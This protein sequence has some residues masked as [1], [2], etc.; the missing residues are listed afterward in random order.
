MKCKEARPLPITLE[1]LA[2]VAMRPHSS[3]CLLAF[4]TSN[5]KLKK[6]RP[7]TG[8][9]Q[10]NMSTLRAMDSECVYVVHRVNIESSTLANLTV[11]MSYRIV[12]LADACMKSERWESVLRKLSRW[13][14]L[15][16][17]GPAAVKPKRPTF[18][19]FSTQPT[20]QGK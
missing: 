10:G 7:H 12:I 9:V 13:V 6:H 18:L 8:K 2:L 19:E 15:G 16:A 3:P 17:L 20:K 14:S 1:V 5:A 11:M 4:I